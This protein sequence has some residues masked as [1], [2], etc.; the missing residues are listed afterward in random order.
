[1]KQ[2]YSTRN[3]LMR[4]LRRVSTTMTLVLLLTMLASLA[5]GVT[6][7]QSVTE[8]TPES[9][10]TTESTSEITTEPTDSLPVETVES[11]PTVEPIQTELAAPTQTPALGPSVVPS[12]EE[13]AIVDSGPVLATSTP[14]STATLQAA[15]TPTPE[16]NTST[17]E[18]TF[19]KVTVKLGDNFGP[20][21][22][23]A[24]FTLLAGVLKV[25]AASG[26]TDAN[27]VVLLEPFGPTTGASVL[28]VSDPPGYLLDE[29][30]VPVSIV[31]GT[32]TDYLVTA[33]A[34]PPTDMTFHAINRST[35]DPVPGACWSIFSVRGALQ[36]DLLVGPL[37]DND[38]D[39]IVVADAV[40]TG[41]Y[42]YRV[43]PP[44]GFVLPGGIGVCSVTNTAVP[45]VT[46]A[47]LP[48][49]EGEDPGS[50][51]LSVTTKT[52]WGTPLADVCITLSQETQ[53][54]IPVEFANG[55]TGDDGNVV[56][57]NLADGFYV[58]DG[59]Q[60]PKNFAVFTTSATIQAP[61]GTSLEIVVDS[62]RF[63]SFD[64]TSKLGRGPELL[65][66]ACWRYKTNAGGVPGD[67]TVVGPVCDTDD[68]GKV[69]LDNTPYGSFCL[70][71]EP[72][73]GYYR[74]NNDYYACAENFELGGTWSV[75]FIPVPTTPTATATGSPTATPTL[76]PTS[77]PVPNEPKSNV[78]VRNCQF[79]EIDSLTRTFSFCKAAPSGVKFGIIQNGVQ[80]ATGSTTSGGTLTIDLPSRAVY[81]L[82]YLEGNNGFAP[83]P[84]EAGRNRYGAKESYTFMPDPPITS[85]TMTV[86]TRLNSYY[87]RGAII[88][89][90]CYEIVN[91]NDEVVLTEQCDT[92]NDGDV[93]FGSLPVVIDREV[94][95][96]RAKM[97]VAPPGQLLITR[98]TFG[99][100]SVDT[101]GEWIST[102]LYDDVVVTVRTVDQDGNLL[103]G[104]GYSAYGTGDGLADAGYDAAD[105]SNDG[106][107][108]FGQRK[109]GMELHIEAR[110]P[111]AGYLTDLAE[112][113]FTVGTDPRVTI[114]F[115][116]RQYG[117]EAEDKA[118][119]KLTFKTQDGE[120]W[121][122]AYQICVTL[123][124]ASG[125]PNDRSLC[126]DRP[127][128]AVIFRN[129]PAGTYKPN[130]TSTS[131]YNGIRYCSISLT[132][133]PTFTIS[134]GDLGKTVTV[135][136]IAT[137]PPPSTAGG[138]C[139]VTLN[140]DS[141]S[142]RTLDI[143]YG[144]YT[145]LT[146]NNVT[147][148]PIQ[149]SESLS[150]YAAEQMLSLNGIDPDRINA[151]TLAPWI[152]NFNSVKEWG[153]L[154][155]WDGN[156]G[157]ALSAAYRQI[158]PNAVM[159]ERQLV[160]NEVFNS[161]VSV[162]F[163]ILVPGDALFDI[164]P[165]CDKDADT[166]FVTTIY[167]ATVNIYQMDATSVG[168]ATP[169]PWPSPEAMCTSTAFR[170]LT[171]AYGEIT[172][173][174]TGAAIF[175]AL[176]LSDRIPAEI[177]ESIKRGDA[178]DIVKALIDDWV[179]PD[180]DAGMW[181]FTTPSD[182]DVEAALRAQF[183]EQGYEIEMPDAGAESNKSYSAEIYRWVNN[184]DLP[185]G[186]VVTAELGDLYPISQETTT[187]VAYIE[188]N[189]ILA[190]KVE[191]T[192][193]RTPEPHPGATTTPTE[194]ETVTSLP[195]TGTQSGG[196]HSNDGWMLLFLLC[197]VLGLIVIR[198]AKH[199]ASHP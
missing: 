58:V 179:D 38:N 190:G 181:P 138:T 160:S 26:C 32:V 54:G 67:V 177:A 16:V 45:E 90:A 130:L 81:Q 6:Q 46:R 126:P 176:Q 2:G 76:P 11:L 109:P 146:S 64:L 119:V 41:P 35:E 44:T 79:T 127:G 63:G 101:P 60:L 24:C 82:T 88:A 92:N 133:Q 97:T 152:E 115:V 137:C 163:Y 150:D 173:P 103:P 5:S 93:V 29:R 162:D 105:G 148:I 121:D 147:A 136:I 157:Y 120:D 72:P 129:L 164:Y 114:T 197:G 50:G 19:V 125:T 71:A 116:A 83:G 84:G 100:T 15:V 20:P 98:P 159:G 53:S 144:N 175:Q 48:I 194:G 75:S 43:T 172:D 68:D 1:M 135:P 34:V 47:F 77:T 155:D 139:F 27:G 51:V 140:D 154:P 182:V 131:F 13:T 174:E 128:Y 87:N 189:A 89:G 61:T 106:I 10:A 78:T 165:Q 141:V 192:P 198:S 185:E 149:L 118:T 191:P 199:S 108:T 124:P 169:T 21:I 123:S 95:G 111:R 3:R 186:C 113:V 73:A 142:N 117:S 158:D 102:V 23:D 7:A 94:T 183:A 180:L 80:V 161:G 30:Q 57:S 112:Q 14:E 99:V 91:A 18:G 167:Y 40:P 196:S 74:P 70:V 156:A 104:F 31:S 195:N 193:T 55:C 188:L 85:W 65:G 28:I 132:N 145:D 168:E 62:V 33:Q 66:G 151:S 143:Y 52:T 22:Q 107:V 153:G 25:W 49:A 122:E 96:Y 184:A 8:I 39:G 4:Q 12:A 110:Y 86:K 134:S 69:I 171:I 187:D 170:A 56:F 37:C 59:F 178:P 36:G 9:E 42:C 17:V 166:L